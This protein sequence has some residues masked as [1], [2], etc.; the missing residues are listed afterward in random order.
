MAGE[1]MKILVINGPNLNRLGQ[2]EPEIYGHAS[3][4]DLFDMIKVHAKKQKVRVTCMQSNYEGKVITAIHKAQGRFDGIVIN[5]AA[6][7]HYSYAVL[8]AL[9]SVTVPAVEVHIS[10]IKKR[11]AFRQHSVTKEA[12]VAQISGKG[13]EGYLEAMDILIEIKQKKERA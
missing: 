1:T 5:P 2:R 6:F 12:C 13:F 7:T 4:K 11:E 8:D 10:D 3:Q 9:K